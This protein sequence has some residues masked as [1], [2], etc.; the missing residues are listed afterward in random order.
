MNRQQLEIA[1]EN[2]SGFR[3]TSRSRRRMT[4]ARWWF[5]QMRIVVD[6]ATD[7]QPAGPSCRQPNLGVPANRGI[8]QN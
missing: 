2:P 7:W 4:R 8:R 5:E 6:Q 3:R 1:F